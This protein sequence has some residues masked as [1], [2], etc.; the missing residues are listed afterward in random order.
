M[1]HSSDLK[2][3]NS[4]WT[5]RLKKVFHGAGTVGPWRLAALM[6]NNSSVGFAMATVGHCRFYGFIVKISTSLERGAIMRIAH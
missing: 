4:V 2:W 3:T 1:N 5:R 6:M